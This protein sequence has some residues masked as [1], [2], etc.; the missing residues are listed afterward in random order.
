MEE[1]TLEW[2]SSQSLRWDGKLCPINPQFFSGVLTPLFAEPMLY[3]PKLRLEF[4]QSPSFITRTPEVSRG[5]EVAH[6]CEAIYARVRVMT[7]K[8]QLARSCRASLVNI[9]EEDRS[10][11]LR[12]TEYSESLQLSWASRGDEFYS[13][14][15]LPR[16]V[17]HFVGIVS[18]RSSSNAFN[19]AIR[20]IPLR[21][22]ELLKRQGLF[23]L[24]II[25]A[26]DG[27]RRRHVPREPLGEEEV[28]R[29]VPGV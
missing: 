12:P 6:V 16:D 17:P 14:R 5:P 7:I 1:E 28:A 26:G 23:R 25:I 10:G 2:R 18:R 15:D 3:W 8:P 4:N 24:S 29:G 13:A 27:V 21:L 20:P 19:L 9:E 11:N 22:H